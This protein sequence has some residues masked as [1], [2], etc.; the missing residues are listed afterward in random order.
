[1]SKS[2]SKH[3]ASS[4]VDNRKRGTVGNFLE[5]KIK[6]EAKLSF[7]S[8]YF[9]IHAYQRLKNNLDNIG[10]MRFLFGEPA[11]IASLAEEQSNQRKAE[12][13]DESLS[14]PIQAQLSQKRAA[15]ECAE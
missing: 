12:I 8:A 7:V 14:I 15:L 6:A 3:L 2:E 10:S 4:I 9:T 5:S 11:F 13:L 1:M